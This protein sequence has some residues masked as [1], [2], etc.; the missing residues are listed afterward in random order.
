MSKR[1]GTFNQNCQCSCAHCKYEMLYD[2]THACTHDYEVGSHT[3]SYEA[4]KTK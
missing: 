3:S 1:A 2:T 4:D